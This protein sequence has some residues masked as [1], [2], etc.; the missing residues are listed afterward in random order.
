MSHQQREQAAAFP[1]SAALLRPT[2]SLTGHE[3]TNMLR[4]QQQQ[5]QT[6]DLQR[7]GIK[8]HTL[9][10]S[11]MLEQGLQMELGSGR[12]TGAPVDMTDSASGADTVF[13]HSIVDALC[14][15]TA[16]YCICT[17]HICGFALHC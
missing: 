9:L 2:T 13:V 12:G 5:L 1:T 6:S 15:N 10:L 17:Y 14:A 3:A 11:A 4:Q 16:L 8:V 7:T